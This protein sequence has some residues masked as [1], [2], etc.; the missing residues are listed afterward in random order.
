MI[1]TKYISA[2]SK[3]NKIPSTWVFENYLNLSESLE[4]QNVKLLSV[5]NTTDT[6]PSMIL[7]YDE[8]SKNYKYKDWSADKQGNHIGFIME[9]FHLD[10]D[11]ACV[12]ICNDYE[13][14]LIEN[15]IYENR[16]IISKGTYKLYDFEI[17]GWTKSDANYW[18]QYN[19]NSN[20]LDFFN[21][22]PLKSFIL[23]NDVTGEAFE[24]E[25]LNMYGYFDNKNELFKI[26]QPL[27]KKKFFK[28]KD[29]IQGLDQLTYNKDYLIIGSSMKDIIAFTRL[30]FK[31]IET[32]APDSESTVLDE[33]LINDLK[34]K[35]KGISTLFDNDN[36]GINSM[37]KYQKIY[38]LPGIHLKLEKDTADNVKIH[39][40]RNTKELLTPKLLKAFKINK[41]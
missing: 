39:G 6:E 4:G 7:Y 15:S 27:S 36:A 28:V 21:V 32:I 18:M 10:Y 33:A 31:N 11:N 8:K 12:K 17:R 9:Y 14:N 38:G 34:Q 24:I 1:K 25:R 41:L 29:H 16:T 40:I 23:K 37:L 19:I 3:V 26:Y 30:R 20:L 35:Y 5:L 2:K 13:G 22:K